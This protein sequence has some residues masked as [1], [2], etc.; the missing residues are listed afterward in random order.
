MKLGES[1]GLESHLI[2]TQERRHGQEE[3]EETSR[4]KDCWRGNY[5]EE[6]K[7]QVLL[8]VPLIA[9]NML[10]YSLQVIS[11]MFNGHLGELPLSGASMGSS[12][13]SVTGFTVLVTPFSSRFF[14]TADDIFPFGQL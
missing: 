8:A 11:I 9:V 14:L 12:F 2:T 4:G 1:S 13:A 7:R 3:E 6:A 5:L 10:Q